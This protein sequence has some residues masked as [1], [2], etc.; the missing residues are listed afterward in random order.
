MLYFGKVEYNMRILIEA[1]LNELL[2]IDKKLNKN[3]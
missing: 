3:S 1:F 2:F